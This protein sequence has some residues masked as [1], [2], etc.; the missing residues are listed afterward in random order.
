V[1]VDESLGKKAKTMVQLA[2]RS[3]LTGILVYH[4]ATLTDDKIKLRSSYQGSIKAFKSLFTPTLGAD[5]Q[6]KLVQS[7]LPAILQSKIANVLK[8]K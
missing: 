6:K 3:E 2:L 4:S 7:L 1:A 5:E 8:M